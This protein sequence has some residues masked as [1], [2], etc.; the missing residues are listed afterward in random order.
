M[1]RYRR[2]ILKLSGGAL[3]GDGRWG[4][5]PQALAH[6]ADEVLQLHSGGVQ[7]GVVIGGGNIF[8]GK[9]GQGWGI[10]PAEADNI[11][12]MATVINGL[13]LR[14]ALVA[15]GQAEVRVLTAIPINAVAEPF[16]RLRGLHHLEHHRILVLTA[17][18]GNPFVT[19]DYAAVQR[20]LELRAE[21]LLAAKD[22]TDG[23]YTSDPRQNPT[24]QRYRTVT[25][26]TVLR[27][28][29]GALDQAAVLLASEQKLP[30][31]LFDFDA[32][33]AARRIC[34]G[35]DIG[36]LVGADGDAIEPGTRRDIQHT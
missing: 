3:A 2:V 15:R 27:Q 33:G 1:Y 20:A 13:L 9:L 5:D 32:V 17:G 4:F 16:A 10:E 11:G 14:G 22:G 6:I 21:A 7:V 12:M 8:R 31:H 24:A 18:T 30:I 29:L 36:T 35:E 26:E 28:R 19:T 34:T 23:L 25:Y